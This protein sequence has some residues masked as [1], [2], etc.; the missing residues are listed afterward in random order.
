M[1]FNIG[2]NIAVRL[3]M[4]TLS[5]AYFGAPGY[6]QLYQP[7]PGHVHL[8]YS[9]ELIRKSRLHCLHLNFLLLTRTSVAT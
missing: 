5:R 4:I 7:L 8:L 2:I 6:F 9:I 3:R 1:N